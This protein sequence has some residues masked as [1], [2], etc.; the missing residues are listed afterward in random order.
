MT[1]SGDNII[2][3]LTPG[4]KVTSKGIHLKTKCTLTMLSLISFGSLSS[5]LVSSGSTFL[6]STGSSSSISDMV[7]LSDCCSKVKEKVR[8]WSNWWHEKV[9][10]HNQCHKNRKSAF[11]FVWQPGHNGKIILSVFLQEDTQNMQKKCNG[12]CWECYQSMQLL[13]FTSE[14]V[15]ILLWNN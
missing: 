4:L 1:L 13:Q 10:Q 11:W 12:L 2:D 9:M 3:Y 5:R 8:F 15:L 7:L 14:S 6:L